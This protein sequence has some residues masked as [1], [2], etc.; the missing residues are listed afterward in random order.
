MQ[1]PS[2][3]DNSQRGH[4]ARDQTG[5][6]FRLFHEL[7]WLNQRHLSRPCRTQWTATVVPHSVAPPR[8]RELPST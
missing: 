4:N 8:G 5:L 6:E 7:Q 2:K 3:Y 1:S